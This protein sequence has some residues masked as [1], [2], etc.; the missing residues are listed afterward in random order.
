VVDES[1]RV[2]ANYSEEFSWNNVTDNHRS[3][4]FVLVGSWLART[5]NGVRID[6][7]MFAIHGY[8]GPTG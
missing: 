8:P 2:S 4:G 7:K 3:S 6:V 1:G 5:G